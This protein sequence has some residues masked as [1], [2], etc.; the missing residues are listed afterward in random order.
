MCDERNAINGAIQALLAN[1]LDGIRHEFEDEQG[2]G[3]ECELRV[4]RAKSV[5]VLICSHLGG[6]AG[7]SITNA[8]PAPWE[9]AEDEHLESG[10]DRVVWIEHSATTRTDGQVS[11]QFEQVIPA[12]DSRGGVKWK[13]L[14]VHIV[15]GT[16]TPEITGDLEDVSF[17]IRGNRRDRLLFAVEE[18]GADIDDD[19]GL[20]DREGSYVQVSARGDVE[21][22]VL[23]PDQT[24]FVDVGEVHPQEFAVRAQALAM[25]HAANNGVRVN[26]GIV[27]VEA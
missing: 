14:G 6:A 15:G 8:A 21:I 12:A 16:R 24:D 26:P 17:E 4:F 25:E 10:D 5:L 23:H 27:A 18:D 13:Q 20:A 2:R 7:V 1:G 11:H 3:G 22:I 19:D 9:Q